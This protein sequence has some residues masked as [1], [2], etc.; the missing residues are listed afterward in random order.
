VRESQPSTPQTSVPDRL[1]AQMR[2]L[3]KTNERVEPR[4]VTVMDEREATYGLSVALMLLM[5]VVIFATSALPD[6]L[7]RLAQMGL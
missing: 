1:V 7:P 3:V 4:R 6:L 2:L 5:V